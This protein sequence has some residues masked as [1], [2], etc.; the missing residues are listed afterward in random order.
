MKYKLE[1]SALTGADLRTLR[2]N[3]SMTLVELASAVG[4]SVG[5]V[6]QVERDLSPV[7][8]AELDMLVKVLDVPLAMLSL[9]KPAVEREAG[10]IVRA[11][12]RR[13]VAHRFDGLFEEL[14]SPDLTD[15]FEILR[16]TFEAGVSL[17]DPVRRATQEIGYI[18]SGKLD[19]WFGDEVFT[20]GSGDSVRIRNEPYRWA[21]PY[22][23][24]AT[25][26]W[27]IAPPVY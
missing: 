13:V 4:R 6:S 11:G 24:P 1:Y 7:N 9:P 27:V 20:V 19:I 22:A 2:K 5:W 26:L 14:I 17:S 12:N 23:K 16:S 8:E 15:E 18:L 10:R 25:A 3:R 21:N